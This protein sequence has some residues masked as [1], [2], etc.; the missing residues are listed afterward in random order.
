MA[1]P[2]KHAGLIC[3]ILTVVTA[4]GGVGGWLLALPVVLVVA[5]LPAVV[6]EVIRTEGRSTRISSV[7]IGIALLVQVAALLIP[8]QPDLTSVLGPNAANLGLPASLLSLTGVLAVAC[9]VLAVVLFTNSR[10][11]YTRWMAVV[12]FLGSAG[13]LFLLAPGEILALLR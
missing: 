6:Y 12:A 11:V 7:L 4:A 3:L 9:V 8:I 1:A 10:G 2:T 5:L 13:V